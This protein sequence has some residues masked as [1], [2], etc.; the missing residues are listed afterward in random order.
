MIDHMTLYDTVYALVA[1]EGREQALLGECG[2]LA[3]EAFR[4]SLAG[5]M[6][7][8]VW[9][10]V[11]M[12]GN[13]RFDLHV[14][15][16]RDALCAGVEFADGA[17][18][19][20]DELF[21]WYEECETGGAGLAFAYD[22]SDG[23]IEAPA[24]H[25]NVN[26]KALQD[27]DTF[28]RIA[29]GEDALCWDLWEA[30]QGWRVWYAGVQEG[31]LPC[32]WTALWRTRCRNTPPRHCSSTTCV[33]GVYGCRAGLPLLTKLVCSSD[34]SQR[35]AVR[36]NA[37]RLSG[38]TLGLSAS[39]P[40]AVASKTRPLFEQG[41]A[42]AGCWASGDGPGGRPLAPCERDLP[43]LVKLPEHRRALAYPPS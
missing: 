11:P 34:F 15:L 2:P 36:R 4:R 32:A 29:G 6:F 38:P 35:A 20:Y 10:E 26:G 33:A 8:I 21:R 25:V 30:A 42:A 13:P 19:G 17:G 27:P 31:Q 22:V 14:A 40:I 41:G 39:F 43:K 28:F 5:D 23:R 7:P 18:N 37:R 16:G 3:R 24:I 1:N 12:Q 9:F